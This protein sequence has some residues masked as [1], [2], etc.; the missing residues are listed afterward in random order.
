MIQKDKKGD[1]AIGPT[2]IDHW[3]QYIGQAEDRPFPL[4]LIRAAGGRNGGCV[5]VV[6]CREKD[7][8]PWTFAINRARGQ[9]R[10][11]SHFNHIVPTSLKFSVHFSFINVGR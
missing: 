6:G 8:T 4:P 5:G 3:R 10:F 1:C 9:S 2:A 11:I 7:P